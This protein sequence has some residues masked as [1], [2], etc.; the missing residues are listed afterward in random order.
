MSL[1]VFNK[2][3]IFNAGVWIQNFIHARQVLYHWAMSLV[4]IVLSF[5]SGGQEINT[6]KSKQDMC[7]HCLTIVPQSLFFDAQISPLET[8][9]GGLRGAEVVCLP[10]FLYVYGQ[11]CRPMARAVHMFFLCLA[12]HPLAVMEG[13]MN[14]GES[15]VCLD[16]LF[17]SAQALKG[18]FEGTVAECHCLV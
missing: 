12:D 18:F 16:V 10:W 6:V 7:Q 8:D 17:L 14:P 4:F 3:F 2:S 1:I 13:A 11:L 9:S 5:F 15:S